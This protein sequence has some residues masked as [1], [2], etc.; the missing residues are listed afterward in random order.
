M[1]RCTYLA[2][3]F[4]Q[5]LY[6][7]GQNKS[8]LIENWLQA[9]ES[10]HYYQYMDVFKLINSENLDQPIDQNVLQ[11]Y[12]LLELNQ[13]KLKSTFRRAGTLLT[14]NLPTP[15]GKTITLRLAE[16]ENFTSDFQ[17]NTPKGASTVSVGKHYRG[18]VQNQANSI[19]AISIFDDQI[20]GMIAT[21][22][23][24]FVLGKLEGSE[25]KY[26][27]Y[28]D[29][30]LLIKNAYGCHTQEQEQYLPEPK[31]AQLEQRNLGD[32]C[33]KVRI[34][35]EADNELFINK[36]SEA[37]TVA[38]LTSIF[39]QM[40]TL[41]QNDGIV[42]VLSGTFVWT[43]ADPYGKTSSSVGLSDFTT[44]WGNQCNSFNGDL[45]HLI[46]LDAMGNGGL[47]NLAV[48]CNRS[49][50]YAYS[51][52]SSSFSSVPTYSWTINV[53]T[54]ETGHNLGSRHTHNCSWNGNS[55]MI[56]GCGPSAS[57]A[58]CDGGCPSACTIGPIPSSAVGGTIMSYC[59]LIAGVGI[60][61]V[62][63]FGSQPRDIMK[64]AITAATCLQPSISLSANSTNIC[65]SALGAI[66]TSATSGTPGYTYIWSNSSTS[67]NLTSVSTPGIYT[68][69]V[70]DANNCNVSLSK[71]LV[72]L[73][74]PGDVV[75]STNTSLCCNN[76]NTTITTANAVNLSTCQTVAWLRTTVPI[77]SY[78]QAQTAF[79]SASPSDLLTSTAINS[80]GAATLVITNND[81]ASSSTYYYTPIITKKPFAGLNATTSTRSTS[82][83]IPLVY[84]SNTYSSG[85]YGPTLPA[86]SFVP[87]SD[88][89]N[90]RGPT[91]YEFT[92]NVTGYNGPANNMRI[93]IRNFNGS[94]IYFTKTGLAG[95]GT[96]V[97]NENCLPSTYNPFTTTMVMVDYPG[98]NSSTSCGGMPCRANFTSSLVMSFPEVP[99]SSAIT[100]ENACDVG[101]SSPPIVL[102][103]CL[104]LPLRLLSFK[105]KEKEAVNLISWE[106]SSEV[107]FDYFIVKK[108]S[109]PTQKFTQIGEKVP[110]KGR[111]NFNTSNSYELIDK[112][113]SRLTYYELTMFNSD[114]SSELSKIVSVLRKDDKESNSLEIYPNPIHKKE[115]LY[116]NYTSTD[117]KSLKFELMDILGKTVY[118]QLFE[119]ISVG[120]NNFQLAIP[121]LP[122]GSYIVRVSQGNLIFNKKL[123]LN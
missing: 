56:D 22:E 80:S 96:Y 78:A 70:T 122:S 60:K 112:D 88:P 109:D 20:Y 106:T 114:G 66:Q 79:A 75:S 47:A 24:N 108:S 91:T 120:P 35:F 49:R 68:V 107:N 15:T 53:I 62:N 63:G 59:H 26:I 57:P 71:T 82:S 86:S 85:D 4:F 118:S 14:M 97:F 77:T 101:N 36:G 31:E 50:A 11:K 40:A 104:L 29:A 73:A 39:N 21:D 98:A 58:Y 45:A 99:A 54:H 18:I 113:P 48:L 27:F 72:N 74:T 10:N 44:F 95:N 5:C 69:T 33:K 103:N 102:S 9:K 13:I 30:D 23:G 17:V 92:F 25:N 90:P 55:T 52:V 6:G 83:S 19:A 93:Q 41:Y 81:C 3:L 123:Q 42:M 1:L 65:S 32:V 37:N 28:N 34:Y 76:G 46:T 8:T 111:N 115:Q 110:S 43:T 38:Y 89:C 51:E 119:N 2:I 12:S 117:L 105:A 61:F 94:T 100:F 16:A 64:N 67:A 116:L 7:F 121:N 84:G 87:P